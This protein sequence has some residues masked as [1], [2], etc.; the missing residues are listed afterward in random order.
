M[1]E[2]KCEKCYQTGVTAGVAKDRERI[3]ETLQP[4]CGCLAAGVCMICDV[5]RVVNDT[6][7]PQT[8]VTKVE[9]ISEDLSEQTD[10][11]VVSTEPTYT[12]VAKE[13]E[14]SEGEN[15]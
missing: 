11:I 10:M 9:V 14:E 8:T 4:Y 7:V 12:T 5:I 15:V 6:F 1:S 3:V 2:H 13:T